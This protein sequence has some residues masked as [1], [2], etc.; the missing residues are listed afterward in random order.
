MRLGLDG[1]TKSKI[2]EIM[3]GAFKV[4]PNEIKSISI[5]KTGMTNQS[6][7]VF[8]GNKGYIVRFPG[9][10][11]NRMINREEEAAVYQVI[12]NKGICDN[13]IYINPENGCKI[14]EY[15]EDVRVCN[16]YRKEDVEKCIGKLK[17]IHT[18]KLQV[19]HEFDI[20]KKIDFYESLLREYGMTSNYE[21]Y[22]QTKENIFSLKGYMDKHME[23]K[24]L[25]HIDAVP[26]N[27]LLVKDGKG[28]EQIRLIDWEYAGMQDPHVDIAMF[29][30][31]S[32]YNRQQMD[33]LI[34]EYFQEECPNYIK[35]KIYCYIAA[36]GLLW[37]NW[38]EYKSS[39]GEKFGEY[40]LCQYQYAKDYY[41]VVKNEVI[42]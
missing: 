36:C 26:D 11:A 38:C 35:T 6:F 42:K 41:N 4:A 16:P 22:E 15:I 28:T 3:E 23:T 31:Y 25:A 33:W 13:V 27:F 19:A 12:G 32:Q 37:S 9:P 40:A 1:E 18:M 17:Q 34:R 8:C 10:G 29:G 30:I 7:L 2:V 20:F 14:T 39:Q 24:V 21:D 5:M